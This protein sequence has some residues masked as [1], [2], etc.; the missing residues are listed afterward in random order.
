MLAPTKSTEPDCPF[1]QVGY[2]TNLEPV[3]ATW[4]DDTVEV[5]FD[6]KWIL[7]RQYNWLTAHRLSDWQRT[8]HSVVRLQ[9]HK[10]FQPEPTIE[11]VRGADI[12]AGEVMFADALQA[13]ADSKERDQ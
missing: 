10:Q 12:E 1:C 4:D 3:A 13:L 7:G 9:L 8:S 5:E 2:P 11:I 6:S